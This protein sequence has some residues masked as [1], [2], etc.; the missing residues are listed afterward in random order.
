MTTTEILMK[1]Y[2]GLN[3]D[4]HWL[5]GVYDYQPLIDS[6]GEVLNQVELGS[7]QGDTTALLQKDNLYGLLQFG[8]GSCSGCD[9]LQGCNNINELVELYEDLRNSIRWIS[10]E[11]MLKFFKEHDWEGGHSWYEQEGTELSDFVKECIV[12]L[13]A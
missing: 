5:Y 13:E 4:G 2:P 10:K 12:Y 8:W 6:F 3:E 1:I 7:Y 9:A 11:E